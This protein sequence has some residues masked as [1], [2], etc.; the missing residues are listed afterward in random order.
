MFRRIGVFGGV[1]IWLAAVCLGMGHFWS[2]DQ[3]AG[4]PG[5]PPEIWPKD[6]QVAL[7]PARF[8]LLILAH[9]KC[10]CTSATIEELS[11][12]MTNCKGRINAYVVFVIPKSAPN[13]WYKADLWSSAGIIPGVKTIVDRDGA[14]ASR[15]QAYTSGQALLYNPQ[16]QLAFRGG[17]TQSRGHIGDNAG[18]SAIEAIV[19]TGKIETDHTVVF[20]CPLFNPESECRVPNHGNDT[21]E[22]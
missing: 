15:F 16:G 7:D 17:I 22:R 10:P 9:P 5:M 8:T 12:L 1:C 21:K 4:T 3:K 2:Y 6:S 19:N 14:E 18:R 11:K 13:D 20:G